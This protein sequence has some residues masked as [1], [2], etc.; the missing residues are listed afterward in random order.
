MAT[1]NYNSVYCQIREIFFKLKTMGKILVNIEE[2]K[3]KRRER[4]SVLDI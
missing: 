4:Y 3:I 2:M 1:T